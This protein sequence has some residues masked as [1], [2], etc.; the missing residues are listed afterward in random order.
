MSRGTTF[1][2]KKRMDN[3][4]GYVRVSIGGRKVMEHIVLAER[5]LGRPLPPMAEVHHVNSKRN[6]NGGHN[7]VICEN[8]LYHH[9]LHRRARAIQAGY[10][11]HWMRCNYCSRYDDPA[12]LYIKGRCTRHRVCNS[13]TKKKGTS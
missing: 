11:A 3:G 5:A 2:T 8:R 7:L 10:P 9:E 4:F 13:T 12:N 6:E 1:E